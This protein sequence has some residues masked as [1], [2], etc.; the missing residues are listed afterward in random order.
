M[1]DVLSAELYG[2]V[3]EGGG[4]GVHEDGRGLSFREDGNRNIW[5]RSSFCG[6]GKGR[7]FAKG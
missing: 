7:A 2:G 4:F 6:T 1:W 5:L 3:M